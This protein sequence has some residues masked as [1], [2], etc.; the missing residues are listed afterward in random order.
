MYFMHLNDKFYSP[1]GFCLPE[2][3]MVR[4]GFHVP[5]R[6]NAF[7]CLFGNANAVQR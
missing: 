7:K 5:G 6:N 3:K 2:R 4:F 1:P